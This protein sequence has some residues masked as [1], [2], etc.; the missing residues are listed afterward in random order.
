MCLQMEP[1]VFPSNTSANV[2]RL[3]LK[4]GVFFA[5]QWS[6]VARTRKMKWC[7]HRVSLRGCRDR[8]ISSQAQIKAPNP[9]KNPQEA[10]KQELS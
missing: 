8:K 1:F 2:E 4:K 9:P 10:A 7:I 6:A 3:K 5:K